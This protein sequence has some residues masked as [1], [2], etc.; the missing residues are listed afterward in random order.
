MELCPV[1]LFVV[2]ELWPVRLFVVMELCPVRLFVVM[3][4]CP[5]RLF[6]VMELSR[7]IICRYGI[8]ARPN[9]GHFPPFSTASLNFG[10]A[11]IYI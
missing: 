7:S 9:L 4:L 5:V 3:E 6:V 2:M 1:R 10:A 8:M 11:V